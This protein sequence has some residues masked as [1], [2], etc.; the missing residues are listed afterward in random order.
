MITSVLQNLSQTRV[1]AGRQKVAHRLSE[2]FH[3]ENNL[4]LLCYKVEVWPHRVTPLAVWR[5]EQL[6]QRTGG[7]KAPGVTCLHSTESRMEA[8]QALTDL[9]LY[10]VSLFFAEIQSSGRQLTFTKTAVQ[11]G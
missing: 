11:P 5:P 1:D 3:K 2:Q 4:D 10:S 8:S 6:E 7:N 9:N